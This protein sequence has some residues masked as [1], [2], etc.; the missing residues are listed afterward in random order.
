MQLKHQAK[1][2]SVL[3]VSS[4]NLLGI[5]QAE[6]TNKTDREIQSSVLYYKE[7][8]RIQVLE[9]VVD[10]RQN[11]NDTS[12]FNIKFVLDTLTGASPSGAIA[13]PQIQT[14]TRPSGRGE[15]QVEPYKI[16]LDDSLP[17]I[18]P[19]Y[20]I[21]T[22]WTEQL[23]PLWKLSLGIYGSLESDY[24]SVGIFSG[25]EKD[26][27]KKNTTFSISTGY[28]LDNSEPVGGIPIPLSSMPIRSQF[29]SND[30]YQK[31]FDATRKGNARSLSKF[32]FS[33]GVT[34]VLNQNWLM[35]LSL[36]LSSISGYQTNS[37]KVL[38]II[39]NNAQ[40]QDIIYESR[41]D[42]RVKYSVFS[43]FKGALNKHLVDLSYRFNTD[44]WG[45]DSH[46][47]DTHYRHNFSPKFY[48][49]IH[50]RYYEQTKAD[51][52]HPYLL[53][54]TPLPVFASADY[55]VGKMSTYTLGVKLGHKLDNGQEISY[56][57][58]YYQQDP[59]NSSG[60]LLVGLNSINLFPK[61][62][63]LIFQL[64]YVF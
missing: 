28:S 46:T 18:H 24:N 41:P 6:D 40:T 57:I 37:Y 59:Q 20:Q 55:R 38:S 1:I 23:S 17:S 26:F 9:G 10:I 12:Q 54:N 61:V 50:M 25:L 64:N 21:N 42:E 48:T 22:D 43:L 4:A 32:D 56:R 13:Q 49:Q 34:Q 29:N 53:K 30:D 3:A 31:A 39:D 14:L 15:Y 60:P 36:S 33:T 8:Q 44:D 51:I 2:V 7:K 58:E 35:Q 62:K 16:P 45:I 5:A 11:F 63:A 19:R 52:Y 27:N 47:I